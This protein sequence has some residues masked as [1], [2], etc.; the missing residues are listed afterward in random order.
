MTIHDP[1]VKRVQVMKILSAI[2]IVI[3]VGGFLTLYV[4]NHFL[5]PI[6]TQ[7]SSN[8]V[9]VLLFL[10]LFVVILFPASLWTSY[11]INNIVKQYTVALNG[12][13]PGLIAR[14]QPR[15]I[16]DS[17]MSLPIVLGIRANLIYFTTMCLISC[18]SFFML[19]FVSKAFPFAHFQSNSP[20]LNILVSL[21]ILGVIGTLYFSSIRSLQWRIEITSDGVR[22]TISGQE[23][24]LGWEE[25]KLFALYGT[26]SGYS[27]QYELVGAKG[28]I[29]LYLP[30]QKN[31]LIP[32][33]PTI[34][35]KEYDKQMQIVFA[36][37][38]TKTR[39][40][41]YDLRLNWYGGI[42]K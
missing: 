40:P 11:I 8:F 41:L 15:P 22:G 33:V 1:I 20:L 32:V 25:I 26:N 21:L 17:G 36:V 42:R 27:L 6:S 39:L 31:L 34:P 14:V 30:T 16:Q 29:R 12:G 18:V 13:V 5:Y 10:A 35:I 2:G 19:I 4:V 37:I 24:F 7:T 3:V 38:A 23:T 9:S 28:I